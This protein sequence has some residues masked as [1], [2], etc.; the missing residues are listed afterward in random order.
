MN[1]RELNFAERWAALFFRLRVLDELSPAA[2]ALEEKEI[3]RVAAAL[4]EEAKKPQE[5]KA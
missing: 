2:R 1:G 5:A 3:D 4:V